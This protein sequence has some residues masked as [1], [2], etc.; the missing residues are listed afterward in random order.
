MDYKYPKASLKYL[1]AGAIAGLVMA[2]SA[3]AD[4]LE[5]IKWITDNSNMEYSGEPLPTVKHMSYPLMEINVFGEQN[6]AQC[7]FS[8]DCE[9]PEL[10]AYYDHDTNEM[11][12]PDGA[13]PDAWESQHIVIH[14]LYHYLQYLN[15]GEPS[16]V[17]LYEKDAYKAHWKWV[18]EHEHP[19]EEPNWL[20]VY[21]LEMACADPY[22]YGR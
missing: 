18:E 14:E 7:E 21:M 15:Y 6:V 5:H 13:D 2:N 9:L 4:M 19:A 11:V 8:P 16:C 1:L 22:G 17:Q 3:K 10:L 12:F 20:F